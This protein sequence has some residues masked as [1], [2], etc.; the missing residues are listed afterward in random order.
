[1]IFNNIEFKPLIH[2]GREIPDYYVSKCG[3]IISNKQTKGKGLPKL[4]DNTRKQLV[5]ERGVNGK[6]ARPLA[7]NLSVPIGFFPEYDYVA[8]TNGAGQVSKKHSKVNI[9][10]HRAVKETWEPI[11]KYPPVSKEDWD[12]SPESMKQFVRESAYVD[13]ID[14]DTSNNHINNLRWTSPLGNS[15]QRK[16][17]G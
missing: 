7:V 3:K 11:D 4:L 13:H 6:Y 8:S 12:K 16:R 2:K 5:E 14:A 1:M 15:S 10:Y 17:K 9:R